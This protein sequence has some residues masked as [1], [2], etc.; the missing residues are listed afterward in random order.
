MPIILEN[1]KVN[2]GIRLEAAELSIEFQD[3]PSYIRSETVLVDLMQ[4]RIGA[5]IRALTGF[6]AYNLLARPK[7]FL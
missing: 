2:A 7:A 3:D 4:C 1:Q 6:G 5:G